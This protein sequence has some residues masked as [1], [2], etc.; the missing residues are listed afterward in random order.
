MVITIRYF[1]LYVL[2]VAAITASGTIKSSPS[3]KPEMDL[4][5]TTSQGEFPNYLSHRVDIQEPGCEHQD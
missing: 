2:K 1:Y 3:Q 5:Y 4:S